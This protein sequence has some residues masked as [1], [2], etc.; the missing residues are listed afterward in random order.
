[1]VSK[2]SSYL[3]QVVDSIAM[4]KQREAR[5][6]LATT[7]L[8]QTPAHCQSSIEHTSTYMDLLQTASPH[9]LPCRAPTL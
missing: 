9:P 5:V 4:E 2:L 3:M 6:Q 1:M 7:Q 8:H